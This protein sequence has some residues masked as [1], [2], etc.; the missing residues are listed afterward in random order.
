MLEGLEAIVNSLPYGA[1]A[2]SLVMAISAVISAVVPDNKMPGWL[3][4][5][6]NFLAA[7]FKNATN[8]PTGE[9]DD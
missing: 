5:G 7:N 6:L 3:A 1:V 9:G 8:A 4:T 2:L